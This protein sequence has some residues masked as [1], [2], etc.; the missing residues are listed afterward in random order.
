VVIGAIAQAA[1]L[2]TGIAFLILC[3]AVAAVTARSLRA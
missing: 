2:R 3:I 1:S